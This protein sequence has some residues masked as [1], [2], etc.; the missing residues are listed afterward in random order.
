MSKKIKKQK[1]S[2]LENACKRKS[3]K[4]RSQGKKAYS[5]MRSLQRDHNIGIP[6][7]SRHNEPTFL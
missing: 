4:M 1:D 3:L 2:T 5:W 7:E 6:P